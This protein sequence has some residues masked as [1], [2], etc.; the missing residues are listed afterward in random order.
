MNVK[1]DAKTIYESS[2]SKDEKILQLRNLILDCKNELDA[3]EQNMRPEVRHNLSEG[4][5]VATN[6]LRELEA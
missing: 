5:R 1:H 3:Q 2:V 6:Y 4:L